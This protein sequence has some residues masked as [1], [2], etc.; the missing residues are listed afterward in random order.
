MFFSSIQK[1]KGHTLLE[2]LVVIAIISLLFPALFLMIR[3]LYA[4]HEYTFSRA[5]VLSKSTTLL[6]EIINDIRAASYAENGALPIA[7][8]EENHLILYTDTDFDRKT[9]RVRYTLTGTNLVKGV[10]EINT[11]AV[12]DTANE[13]IRVKSS[14]VENATEGIILFRYFDAEGNELDP[15]PENTLSV[16]RIEVTL[17]LSSIFGDTLSTREVRGSASIR[18]L[19]YIY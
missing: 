6:N 17:S 14:R 15:L 9:E 3:S 19:K 2:T 4:S 1:Q 8:M 11:E 7:E 13:S 5:L 12:Y 18:N 10:T 16:K